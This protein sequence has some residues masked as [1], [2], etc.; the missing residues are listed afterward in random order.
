MKMVFSKLRTWNFCN[1]SLEIVFQR[2]MN[3]LPCFHAPFWL[4][5]IL[6]YLFYL[7]P[8]GQKYNR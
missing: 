4:N 3:H 2:Y 5:H 7:C 1:F 8:V 6:V